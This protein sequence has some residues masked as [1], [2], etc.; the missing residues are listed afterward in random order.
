MLEGAYCLD[1]VSNFNLQGSLG[2]SE[3]KYLEISITRCQ[4]STKCEEKEELDAFI[5]RL[6]IVFLYNT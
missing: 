4:N 6:A 1:D 2:T 3:G 5:D